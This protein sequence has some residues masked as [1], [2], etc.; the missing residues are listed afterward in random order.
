AL[1]ARR[2]AG[3]WA[4]LSAIEEPARPSSRALAVTDFIRQ[5]GASFFDE[6]VEG[7]GL[8][9][10]QVEEALAELVAL[11]L[12]TSDSFAGL[13]AL[14][15]PSSGGQRRRRATS[16][17]MESAGRWALARRPRAPDNLPKAAA[18]ASEHLA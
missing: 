16:F 8:L 15:A 17:A 1:L 6:L 7:S 11:G 10:P 3:L 2:H 9:R 13:R 4:S 5:Y 12:V 18:E 14:L